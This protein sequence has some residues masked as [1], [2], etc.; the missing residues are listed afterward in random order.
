MMWATLVRAENPKCAWCHEA[1]WGDPDVRVKVLAHFSAGGGR[2]WEEAELVGEK[3]PERVER[4]R[5]VAGTHG[6]ALLESNP[7]RARIRIEVEECPLLHAVSAS[8][9]LPRFPFE[10]KNG[11]DEWL[12]IS[13]RDQAERFVNGLRERGV[14]VEIASS[15]EYKP[16]ATL[17][18]RQRELMQ[19]AIAQGY[20][21]VPRR[22]T[23]TKLA[24]RL[25]VAKSTL[26]ET[27]ARG[28]RHLLEDLH[29]SRP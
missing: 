10:I 24:E 23:L 1:T 28:E 19:A 11:A 27:L 9:A 22:I 21:E 26:S 5:A 13:E 12:I 3:W 15:R 29:A 7:D 25:K 2:A 20:Y 4:I 16:H 6:V 8:G 14:K 17:T 18:D